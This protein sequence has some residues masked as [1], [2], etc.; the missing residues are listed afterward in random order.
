MALIYDLIIHKNPA[1]VLAYNYLFARFDIKLPLR[2][3]LV[4]ASTAGI[5][6]NRDHSQSVPCI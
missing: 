5:T 6:L 1:A 3:D 2:R 4:K